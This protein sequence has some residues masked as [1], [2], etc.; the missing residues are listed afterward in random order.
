MIWANIYKTATCFVVWYTFWGMQWKTKMNEIYGEN[1][2]GDI[3]LEFYFKDH[4]EMVLLMIKSF[5]ESP[6]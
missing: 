5:Y 4:L 1:I 3:I 2:L 6:N